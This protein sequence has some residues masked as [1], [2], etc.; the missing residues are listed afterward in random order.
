M[1]KVT[2][3]LMTLF[4]ACASVY[5]QTDVDIT[6]AKYKFATCNVGPFQYDQVCDHP[7]E[8]NVPTFFSAAKSDE[9]GFVYLFSWGNISVD[10]AGN[11]QGATTYVR[12]MSNIVNLGGE[13][14]K[15]WC[16]KG[17]NCPDEVF[18]YGI[19][20][21]TD[22]VWIGWMH[23]A[24]YFGSKMNGSSYVSTQEY[25]GRLSITW[26]L[27]TAED[28]YSTTDA[29]FDATVREYNGS[30]KAIIR[31]SQ[32]DTKNSDTWCKQE[33]D[34]KFFGND[35][36]VPLYIKLSHGRNDPENFALLIKEFKITINPTTPIV[37]KE[38]FTLS[39]GTPSS[40][41]VNGTMTLTGLWKAS[42][43]SA[44]DLSDQTITNIDM[45]EITIPTDAPSLTIANPNCL[46]Y[47]AANASYP[48]TWKNVVKGTD[49]PVINLQDGFD[50]YN[51]KAFNATQ[52]NY[53][54]TFA[55]GWN[56]LALPF[57]TTVAAGD[58][59]EEYSEKTGT[60]IQFTTATSINANEAYL[61]KIDADKT[62]KT[63]TGEGVVPVTASTGEIFK[64]NFK[65]LT[66]TDALYKYILVIEGDKEVF[67]PANE[68]A[69]VAAFRGY[70]DL[71]QA[72]KYA[73]VHG[74]GGTTNIDRTGADNGLKVYSDNGVLIIHADEVQNVQIYAL[75]GRM[76]KTIQLAEGDNTVTGLAK[77]VYLI[78]N[79]K[80]I[81]K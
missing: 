50:F 6:P 40:E 23:Q 67:A 49:A 63:F 56:T 1:K 39:M 15:V 79:K 41:T 26:R 73:I 68:N 5:A 29:I 3:F 65:K 13:V 66:G 19:K 57:N 11:D 53:T 38:T 20:P 72:P 45:T 10:Q 78:N 42:D 31:A 81:V 61:I 44:L 18:P 51:T 32:A 25:T 69:T 24:L 64:N 27:C 77:G 54:R 22:P 43:F 74:G 62:E 7:E 30:D 34:F 52:I 55:K 70:L 8:S 33:V 80:A 37:E 36:N 21:T 12:Q 17:H 4:F 2:F 16:M 28:N 48:D 76:V 47:V 59:I 46:I 35:Q 60:S 71:T 9:G 75:D 58:D 14:G